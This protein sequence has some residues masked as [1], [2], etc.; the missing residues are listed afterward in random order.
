M[1]KT[2]MVNREIKRAAPAQKPLWRQ[3]EAPFDRARQPMLA[4]AMLFGK[5]RDC[6]IGIDQ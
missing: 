2:S 5:I 4:N 6:K 1:A 3:S